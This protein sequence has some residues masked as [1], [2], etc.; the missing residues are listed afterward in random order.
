[1]RM[2]F[3]AALTIA[4]TLSSVPLV[5]QV[6]STDNQD[7]RKIAESQAKIDHTVDKQAAKLSTGQDKAAYKAQAKAD[8]Q[9]AK[10]LKSR[11]VKKAAKE[12]DKAN[13]QV[14]RAATPQ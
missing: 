7:A 10:A 6:Q 1:M 11:S 3:V 13:T 4:T 14:D 8:K 5:A 2:R 12:Q 9:Q